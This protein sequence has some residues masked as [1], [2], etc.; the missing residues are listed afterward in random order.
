MR[1]FLSYPP[2]HR[3]DPGPGGHPESNP[4]GT[5]MS[6]IVTP[7]IVSFVLR[8]FH[9]QLPGCGNGIAAQAILRAVEELA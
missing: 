3:R 1:T 4:R 5:E 2:G 6:E 8:D 9:H 7:S